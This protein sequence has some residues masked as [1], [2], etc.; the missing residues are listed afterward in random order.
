MIEVRLE[1]TYVP[2]RAAVIFLVGISL[3]AILAYLPRIPGLG[4]RF[5]LMRYVAILVTS[6]SIATVLLGYQNLAAFLILGITRTAIALYSIWILL[7]LV[8]VAFAYL[9]DEDTVRADRVRATLGM[10]RR[11]S[12]TATGF[13]RLVTELVVWIAFG[14]YMIYVW[15]DSG[16]TLAQLYATFMVGF[17]LGDFEFVPY[18]LIGGILIFIGVLIA[19]GWVKRWL[20]RRWLRE[21]EMERGARESV[22][23]LF[24]YVGFVVA[25]LIALVMA[26]VNLTGL[27]LVS[28]AL[29]LGLG[30]GLQEIA[31]NFVS[32]II[33]LFEAPD[34][35]WRL[36]YRRRR[37][38]L[39]S[40]HSHSRHRDRDAR[41]PERARAEL[42]TRVRPRHELGASGHAG[43]ARGAGR[44]RVRVGCRK[45]PRHTRERCGRT[46][47]GH[48]G[49]ARAGTE[50]VFYGLR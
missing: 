29:A 30:F 24:G 23:T 39:R 9:R 20:D 36:R 14:V 41:Q 42:G 40:E 48:H 3:L 28:G 18:K 32:G 22:I 19:I 11:G 43:A 17:K 16:N 35:L 50:G 49:R 13:M 45:S 44:R 38:G 33:L 21:I 1:S 27:A 4:S 47:G 2:G 34:P 5:K 6:A 8:S 25:V 10:S 31:N 37:S 46:L 7:W 12:K 26:D 15:D